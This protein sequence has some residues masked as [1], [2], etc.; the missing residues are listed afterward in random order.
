[1]NELEEQVLPF[2][3]QIHEILTCSTCSS[4]IKGMN[5]QHIAEKAII[6]GWHIVEG[7]IYCAACPMT[8][9]GWSSGASVRR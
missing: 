3:H 9:I 6:Q 8:G 1:M 4:Y 7:K 5:N 2:I